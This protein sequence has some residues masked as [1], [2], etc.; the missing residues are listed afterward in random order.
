MNKT[1][2]KI[3]LVL[4]LQALF[5]SPLF[6]QV[7][8]PCQLAE[9]YQ[10]PKG[11]V[12]GDECYFTDLPDDKKLWLVA[13]NKP[14]YPEPYGFVDNKGK[15]VIPLQ[16]ERADAFFNGVANVRKNGKW[17]YINT[18]NEFVI[19]LQYDRASRFREGLAMVARKQKFGFINKENQIVIPL[20]Y[21]DAEYFSD[22]LAS[23]K[24]QD[25]WGV[26]NKDNKVIV[27]FEYKFTP[28]YL[29]H[30][31]IENKDWRIWAYDNNNRPKIFDKN[32]NLMT[33]DYEDM[34]FFKEGLLNA[35]KDGKWGFVNGDYQTVIEFQYDDAVGFFKKMAKVQKDGK[36]GFINPQG[37][38]VIPIEYDKIK[39]FFHTFDVVS[40]QKGERYYLLKSDGE[41]ILTDYDYIGDYVSDYGLLAVAKKD[42]KSD[43]LLYGAIDIKKSN[44]GKVVIPM[45]Y[46]HLSF[47]PIGLYDGLP[48]VLTKDKK[49]LILDNK[50]EVIADKTE[51]Y[52]MMMG[53]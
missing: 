45:Q 28:H 37:K 3:T 25:K 53:Y 8:S 52:K 51:K 14:I 47:E 29:I 42:P 12:F 39:S 6:A 35:K 32:G 7:F 31:E 27:P 21:D 43:K 15:I 22:G 5:I 16:Y 2:K 9:G 13:K 24:K 49:F 44:F 4:A 23:V 1:M 33:P 50:G 19:P 26:I 34:G 40:A 46:Q 48:F 30:D 18:K 20:E 17:G 11:L 36:Y 10:L 41:Q 38:A